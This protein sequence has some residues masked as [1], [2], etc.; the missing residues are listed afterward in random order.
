MPVSLESM[1]VCHVISGIDTDNGGPPVALAG[2]AAAQVRAG[3]DVSVLSSF[4]FS[5]K[6]LAAKA[7]ME[8]NGVTVRLVGPARE[9]M[10]RHP[11]LAVAAREMCAGNDV[12]HVHSMWEAIQHEACLAARRAGTPY[13]MT[14]H[15][16][17]DSWS[18][19][20]RI[21]FALR[22]KSHV[23]HAAAI[24]VATEIER[25]HVGSLGLRPRIIVEPHGLN[26]A[27]FRVLPEKGAFRKRYPA[28]GD[29]PYVVFLGRL[30]K[31]KGLELLVPAFAKVKGDARLVIVGPD[32]GMREPS[33]K[34]ARELGISDRVIFTGMLVGAD[35]VAAL[36]DATVFSLP[37]YHENFGIAVVEAL[38]AGVPVVVS[39]H[40][41]LHPLVTSERVGG[42]VPLDVDALGGELNRWLGDETMR[43]DA[44]ERARPLALERFDWDVIAR[45]WG[46]HYE[47]I[48]ERKLVIREDEEPSP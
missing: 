38:A 22:M 41:Q 35:R 11:D 15:G 16:M 42:V 21:Y 47:R 8:G 20:K 5:E 29:H 26:L 45:N 10:S 34:I 25:D 17:L 24:H 9:P 12:L 13:V 44:G 18:L 28:V 37:S 14:P 30:D 2:L 36:A 40:V 48:M 7:A 27:E 43:R 33:Q 6:S 3:M 1:R 46:S 31:R 23:Q 39:D 32:F 4:R 19:K